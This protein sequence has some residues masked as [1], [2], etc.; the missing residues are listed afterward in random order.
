M[1]AQA[2]EPDPN[3]FQQRGFILNGIGEKCWFTQSYFNNKP[4][5]WKKSFPDADDHELRILTF[6]NPRCMRDDLK[7][8]DADISRM[9][10]SHMINVRLSNFYTGTYVIKDANFDTRE[11][12]PHGKF[13][14]RGQ[15][16]QSKQY[17]SKGIAVE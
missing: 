1:S 10:N 4:H 8:F 11:I 12:K 7:G 16:I 2:Q 5:F 13:E 17:P 14:D 6:T 15:C 9:L 3:G